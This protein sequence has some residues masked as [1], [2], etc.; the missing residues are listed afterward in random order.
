MGYVVLWFLMGLI[1]AWIGSEKGRSTDGFC[2]GVLLGPIG[3][4]IIALM[5]PV[6]GQ[7]CAFCKSRMNKDATVCHQCQREQPSQKVGGSVGHP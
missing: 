1:G 3:L 5:R 6:G 4:V 7:I 2:L